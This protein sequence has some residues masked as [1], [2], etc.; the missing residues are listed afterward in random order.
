MNQEQTVSEPQSNLLHQ[1]RGLLHAHHKMVSMDD[2]Q[3]MIQQYDQD[4]TLDEHT[5]EWIAGELGFRLEIKRCGWDHLRNQ[6]FPILLM[7]TNGNALTLAAM[8]GDH[9]VSVAVDESGNQRSVRYEAAEI[10]KQFARR[11][12]TLIPD[13]EVL[14]QPDSIGLKG[15][16]A[17]R[18]IFRMGLEVVF[19][20]FLISSFQLA[21]PLFTMNVYD[22]VVPNAATETLFVLFSGICLVLLFDFVFRLA[23]AKILEGISARVGEVL[24]TQ[25]LRKVIGAKVKSNDL[26]S[27]TD[28]FHEI[29]NFRAGFFSRTIIELV[30]FPAFFLF[31]GVIYYISPVIAIIPVAVGGVILLVHALHQFPLLRLGSKL[32]SYRKQRE[33]FLIETL[34]GREGI[35][36]ANGFGRIFYAWRNKVHEG[37]SL[38][39]RSQLWSAN[40]SNI[41]PV[42]VQ[43]VSVLVILVGAQQIFDKQ[44]SMGALIACSIL[45][46]R[47]I[48]P[49]INFFGASVRL[50]A[51][52]PMLKSWKAQLRIVSD[53]DDTGTLVSKGRK[54]GSIL[55]RDV[56]FSYAEAGRANIRDLNLDIKPNEKVVIV[57]RSGA[58]KSTLLRLLSGLEAPT[59]GEVYL[60]HYKMQDL[61]AFERYRQIGF[62]PQNPDFFDGTVRDNIDFGSVSQSESKLEE[63]LEE[64]GLDR[65]LLDEV[66]GGGLA[67]QVG[68]RGRRLSGGQRQIVALMRTLINDSS[69]YLLDEPTS[70]M[71]SILEQRV[72]DYLRKRFENRTAIFVS[73]RPSIFALADRMIVMEKGK[74]ILDGPRDEVASRCFSSKPATMQSPKTWGD[75]AI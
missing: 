67:F 33:S 30:E 48:L 55:A 39:H 38:N 4:G 12:V 56:Q 7:L 64:F 2:L 1:L 6:T 47:A 15:L 75:K 50:I 32:F 8:E 69:V 49:L 23:R 17:K 25:L 20:S 41:T 53:Y 11:I 45:S 9:L 36:L 61:H 73:H 3:R 46:G 52:W 54:A 72:I 35:K 58:G 31:V 60:D 18:T 70:G 71:D 51:A 43:S 5:I 21:L 68:E 59:E 40:L 37:V 34:Q 19:A 63:I 10:A 13:A 62:M 65:L 14:T 26:G 57:G 27:N 66:S 42:L 28:M 16:I 22:K 29:Q 74:I 24:E 44:L